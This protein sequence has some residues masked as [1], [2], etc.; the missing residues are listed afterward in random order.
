ACAE[1]TSSGSSTPASLKIA[2]RPSAP[3]T[4]RGDA[5]ACPTRSLIVASCEQP[6]QLDHHLRWG[7]PTSHA[8]SFAVHH[9]CGRADHAA[10]EQIH[11]AA[12]VAARVVAGQPPLQVTMQRHLVQGRLEHV[13]M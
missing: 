7:S 13:T 10:H 11:R 5:T 12:E 1:A 8:T 2:T 3:I 6:A 9:G 4:A